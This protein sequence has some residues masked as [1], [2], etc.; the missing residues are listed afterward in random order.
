MPTDPPGRMPPAIPLAD[1]MPV[2]WIACDHPACTVTLEVDA[3]SLDAVGE[4]YRAVDASRA[5]AQ[6]AAQMGWQVDTR[7]G[8]SDF[9]ALDYCPQHHLTTTAVPGA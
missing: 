8:V 4:A 6:L 7:P 2:V 1:R 3:N 5:L 9:E